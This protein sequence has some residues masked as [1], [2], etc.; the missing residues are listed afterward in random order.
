MKLGPTT[1]TVF[2]MAALALPFAGCTPPTPQENFFK[3]IVGAPTEP[4]HGWY[5]VNDPESGKANI[6]ELIIPAEERFVN[7]RPDD[8]KEVGEIEF[9]SRFKANMGPREIRKAL[10]DC[11][12]EVISVEPVGMDPSAN[13]YGIKVRTSWEQ[14]KPLLKKDS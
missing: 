3:S 11:K 7:S 13:A 8:P 12:I 2:T 9:T 14:L 4:L 10:E 1:R 5:V 6:K